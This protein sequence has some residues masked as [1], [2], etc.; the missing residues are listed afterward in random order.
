[1]AGERQMLWSMDDNR[2]DIERGWD[3]NLVVRYCTPDKDTKSFVVMRNDDAPFT[4][5]SAGNEEAA[6]LP[7]S[8]GKHFV[9]FVQVSTEKTGKVQN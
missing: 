2:N 6:E 7:L 5:D 3:A 4:F 1:M 8:P 9:Y